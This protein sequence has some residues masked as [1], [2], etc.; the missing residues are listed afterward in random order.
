MTE[1]K[2]HFNPI[3]GSLLNPTGGITGHRNEEYYKENYDHIISFHTYFH[4]AGGYL[5]NYHNIGP[6]YNYIDLW[7]YCGILRGAPFACLVEGIDYCKAIFLDYKI[8]ADQPERNAFNRNKVAE[9]FR[10]P[11]VDI[12]GRWILGDGK[13]IVKFDNVDSEEWKR[14]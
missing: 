14:K 10:N 12:I 13:E 1:Y 2:Q 11:C 9:R 4:D 8:N 5:Y 7:R 6:G 3:F